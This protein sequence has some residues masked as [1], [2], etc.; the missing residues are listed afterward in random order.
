MLLFF[1]YLHIVL[2]SLPNDLGIIYIYNENVDLIYS[3]T[4]KEEK[5]FTGVIKYTCV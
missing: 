5:M 4:K 1:F 3:K 2:F